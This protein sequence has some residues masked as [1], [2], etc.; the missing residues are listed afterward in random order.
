MNGHHLDERELWRALVIAECHPDFRDRP[1]MDALGDAI[2]WIKR[3]R[4]SA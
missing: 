2:A 3:Q 4:R 1:Q